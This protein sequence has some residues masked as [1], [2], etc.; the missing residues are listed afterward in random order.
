MDHKMALAVLAEHWEARCLLEH[1]ILR[2][3]RV[4]IGKVW[5]TF[6]NRVTCGVCGVLSRQVSTTSGAHFLQ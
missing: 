3:H 6:L 5:S 2:D 4:Q 1:D